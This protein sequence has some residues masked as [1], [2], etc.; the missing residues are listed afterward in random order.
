MN[1][2]RE[3][4]GPAGLVLLALVSLAATPA[5]ADGDKDD[6][7]IAGAY[8]TTVLIATGPG[9]PP[10]V[11]LEHSVFGPGGTLL[12]E[13]NLNLGGANAFVPPPLRVDQLTGYGN[14]TMQEHGRI[15]LTFKRWLFAGSQTPAALFGNA[16]VGQQVGVNTVQATAS[17][18]DGKIVDGLL[19][20]QF[21]NL[22]GQVV[23]AG[24]GTWSAER[25]AIEPLAN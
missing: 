21:T 5:R 16:A 15:A 23:F 24:S 14:W 11:N 20:F 2:A 13:G 12:T 7:G 3:S 4:Y 10:L 22:A 1:R 8:L 18:R 19:T 6:R 9:S 17:V 25:I